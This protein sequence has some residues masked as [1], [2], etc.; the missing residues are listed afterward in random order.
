MKYHFVFLILFIAASC[1]KSEWAGYSPKNEAL[2]KLHALGEENKFPRPGDYVAVN[3]NIESPSFLSGY[4]KIKRKWNGIHTFRLSDTLK[5]GIAGAITN[6]SKG[7]SATF[8]IPS[9]EVLKEMNLTAERTPPPF[10]KVNIKLL[11]TCTAA[12]YEKAAEEFAQ[13]QNSYQ[14]TEQND[15]EIYLKENMI[16]IA[17]SPEGLYY[18]ELKKGRGKRPVAGNTVLVHYKGSFTNGQIFDNTYLSGQPLEFI[19]GNT[20]QAIKGMHIGVKQMREGEKAKLV[21]PSHL[22]FGKK[23]SSTGIVTAG[24]T[25]VYEVELVEIKE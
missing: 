19:I 18:L 24:K 21:I 10:F 17:P 15:L 11:N 13:W 1:K 9:T 23:G 12:E 16:N 8:A 20:D 6:L 14:T 5:G 3:I 2:Y 25:L 7:D 4:Y 22:A